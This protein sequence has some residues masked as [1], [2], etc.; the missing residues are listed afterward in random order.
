M[1]T[2]AQAK[3]GVRIKVLDPTPECPASVVAEQTLGSFRDPATIRRA[4]CWA[5]NVTM[6][7]FSP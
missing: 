3:M 2:S 1:K 6:E 4:Q 5:A 7:I